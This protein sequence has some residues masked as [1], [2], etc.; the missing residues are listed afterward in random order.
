M[1]VLD[2]FIL[3]KNG[4]YVGKG[5]MSNGLFKMKVMTV[6]PPIKNINNKNTSFAYMLVS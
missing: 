1:F 5:Y 2:N 4:M 3:T 6:I